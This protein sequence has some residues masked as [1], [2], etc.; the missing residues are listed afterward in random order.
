VV[1]TLNNALL[2]VGSKAMSDTPHKPGFF[3]FSHH[4]KSVYKN[5]LHE[6]IVTLQIIHW[7]DYLAKKGCSNNL[8]KAAVLMAHDYLM[9][10]HDY[11][12]ERDLDKE[13]GTL[14]REFKIKYDKK[15]EEEL[16]KLCQQNRALHFPKPFEPELAT[17]F[18]LHR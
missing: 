15:S 12:G 14:I 7:L 5:E 9:A 17:L 8:L 18:S 10:H 16:T 13:L 11:L 1:E 3:S 4:A 6:R 2:S